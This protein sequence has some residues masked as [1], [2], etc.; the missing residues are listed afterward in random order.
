MERRER[1]QGEKKP[2][3]WPL[4]SLFFYFSH[5]RKDEGDAGI[6]PV[7][8]VAEFADGNEPQKVPPQFGH[9]FADRGI[10]RE[11]LVKGFHELERG[12]R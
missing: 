5:L 8:V 9:L 11:N 4:P 10:E 12:I 1:S 2:N 3:R 7:R 6:S